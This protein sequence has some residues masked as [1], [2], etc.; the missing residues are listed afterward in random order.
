MKR[1]YPHCDRMNDFIIIL[2]WPVLIK[3]DI[4]EST[5]ILLLAFLHKLGRWF[6]KLNVLSIVIP[7]KSTLLSLYIINYYLLK[8]Q[9]Y[10]QIHLTIGEISLDLLLRHY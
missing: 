9:F 4:L 7:S 5:R 8:Q 3:E 10:Y 1:Q 2:R 6:L